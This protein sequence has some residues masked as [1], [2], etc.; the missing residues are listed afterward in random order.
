MTQFSLKTALIISAGLAILLAQYPYF[1]ELGSHGQGYGV[2][3]PTD[4]F[5]T[6][7]VIEV[8]LLM[9]WACAKHGRFPWRVVLSAVVVLILSVTALLIAVPRS[10]DLGLISVL[11]LALA[12]ILS[13]FVGAVY[14]AYR[15]ISWGRSLGA[16]REQTYELKSR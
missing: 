4:R 7:A 6:V 3:A 2:Y 5:A 9:G 8:A 11:S 12:V 10:R 1:Y 16:G 14:A 15:V 13:T